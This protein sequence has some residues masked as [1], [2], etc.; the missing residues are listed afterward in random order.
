MFKYLVFGVLSF[1]FFFIAL[2]SI[3]MMGGGGG[4]MLKRNFWTFTGCFL[5]VQLAVGILFLCL[6]FKKD[7][8]FALFSFISCLIPVL[9]VSVDLGKDFFFFLSLTPVSGDTDFFINTEGAFYQRSLLKGIDPKSFQ[10][11]P[12]KGE[13]VTSTTYIQDKN[14]VYALVDDMASINVYPMSVEKKSFSV[15]TCGYATD[16][17]AVY[18]GS[19]KV[20][21]ANPKTFVVE[22][23]PF[24][25]YYEASDGARMYKAGV[26]IE[27]PVIQK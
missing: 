21:G 4:A 20:E 27:D 1:G 26:V 16:D 3:A 14:G 25:K 24:E 22:K 23:F 17:N 19:K 13:N 10:L 11:F 8:F 18:Y 15:L 6:Y 9:Y 12:I 7:L 2:A 5:A